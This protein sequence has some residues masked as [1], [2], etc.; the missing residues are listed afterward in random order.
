MQVE[1]D[2]VKSQKN[3]DDRGLS[4]DL[5]KY[6]DFS[7]AIITTDNRKD[8]GEKRYKAAG[9]IFDRL[10]MLIFT[11]RGECIRIISLRKA[12]KREIESYDKK[13]KT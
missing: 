5:V 4:F 1:F 8:Y 11:I 6:F 9:Y 7:T 12:N 13:Q 2:P 3:I 10:Y